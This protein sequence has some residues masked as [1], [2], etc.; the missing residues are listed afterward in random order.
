MNEEDVK[1]F[2]DDFKKAKVEDKMNMWFYALEQE[3][4][5]DEIMDE[6]S[7][8]ARIQMMKSGVKMSAGEE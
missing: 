7:K 6:M 3:A 1:S 8:L 5:W 2:L 4:I